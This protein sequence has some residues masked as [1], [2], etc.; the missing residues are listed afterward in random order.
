[1]NVG[2]NDS[3]TLSVVTN[4]WGALHSTWSREKDSIVSEERF[5]DPAMTA[6]LEAPVEAD[7]VSLSASAVRLKSWQ[8]EWDCC[9]IL[10]SSQ[11]AILPCTAGVVLQNEKGEKDLTSGGADTKL[12]I[13]PNATYIG[14]EQ[15]LADRVASSLFFIRFVALVS[16]F[17]QVLSFFA[18]CI[19]SSVS[20]FRTFQI[21][22]FV[23]AFDMDSDAMTQST[24]PFSC[25][26]IQSS[27][28][29]I[30]TG[31]TRPTTFKAAIKIQ[32]HAR[33]YLARRR[34][35]RKREHDLIVSQESSVLRLHTGLT[36][37]LL[38]FCVVLDCVNVWLSIKFDPVRERLWRQTS[39]S[40]FILLY[41]FLVPLTT[42]IM[43][44][45]ESQWLSWACRRLRV[46][47]ELSM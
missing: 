31:L 35:F 21:K 6:D 16:L 4:E 2:R 39:E 3:T 1:M 42:F 28:Q 5:V 29:G 44:L 40:G 14:C 33:V 12:L 27:T 18:C 36:L 22:L 20:S 41:F 17:F 24:S 25:A 9:G 26:K 46:W 37:S 19:L 23:R 32:S 10:G 38:L 13:S 8:D 11:Y 45:S 30:F 7:L 47:H 34:C 43:L 15:A